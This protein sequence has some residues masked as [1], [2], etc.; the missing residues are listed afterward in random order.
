MNNNPPYSPKPQKAMR[1]KKTIF[2]L[3]SALFVGATLGLP[4]ALQAQAPGSMP[5]LP[6]DTAVRIGKLPNGLTYFI[7]HNEEPKGRAEFYIA[8]KVGS[9]QEE[10]SQQGLAHFLEHIAFNGTK[11]FPGKGI[12][13]FLESI[14]ASF[15]GNINAYTSFDRTVYTLMKIPVPRRSIV[16]SCIL[17][18]HDWSSFISLEDKEIDAERGVIEEEWRRSNN[19]DMRNSEKLLGVA[20]PGNKYGKRLPIGKMDIV[21]NFP[22]QV[23]RDYYKKWYRPDL[24]SVIIV[25]D[26]DVN[27]V[28]A[29]LKK[30]FADIPAPVNAAERVYV[31]VEDNDKPIVGI[32]SDKEATQNSLVIAYKSDVTPRDVRASIMGPL[33][34]YINT[35]VTTMV[36]QRFSD[37][38]KKPNAPFTGASLEVGNYIVAKTKDASTFGATFKEGQWEPALKALVAEIARIK[39]YG[40]TPAEFDRAKKDFLVNEKNTYNERDKRTSETWAEIYVDYFDDGGY[41]LDIPTY[42]QLIQG[43][44]AQ[45]PLDQINAMMQEMDLE[46]NVLVALTSV[47]KPGVKLPSVAELTE[48]YLAYTKQQVEAPKNEVSNEKLIDKLPTKG[49]IVKEEKN[50]QYGSTVWTLSNGTKVYFKKTD[51]KEDEILFKGQ[52]KGGYYNFTKPTA[53]D[54]KVLNAVSALGGLGKFDASALEKALTGRLAAITSSVSGIS[55]DVAGS[56]TKEDLETLLQLLYLKFTAVRSDKEAFQAWQERTISE[57][58]ASKANPLSFLGDS[59]TRYLFP[60]NPERYP[61]S[62]QE[63]KG[64]NY[65]KALQLF[66]SRFANARGFDFYFVGNI[67][68]AVLRPLVEQ[69]IAALPAQKV[70]TDKAYT[71]RVPVERLGTNKK[72]YSAPM[73]TPMGIVIDGLSLPSTYSQQEV[74][75]AAVLESILDQLYTK[76]IREDAGGAYSVGVTSEVGRFP[77]PRTSVTVQFQT[78]PAKAVA[79]NEL[80]FKGLEG[81]AKEGPSAEYFDKAVKNMKKAHGENLRK[82]SYWLAQLS[83]F[84]SQGF[85]FV[86]DYDKVLDAVTPQAVQALTKKLYDSKDRTSILFR[87][88]EV[89]EKK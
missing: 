70:Y 77:S 4:S 13:N 49:K 87:S 67:D 53:T 20:F 50:A 39:K 79:M 82:N 24:Q 54:L 85:D 12:I 45:L 25:G 58:E 36:N 71:N 46:K 22:Y 47:E 75:T 88:T 2:S 60:N 14:G 44:V 68:E 69:Y 29:Q 57:L 64:A 73:A 5:P 28:E 48:K 42:Y 89:K 26:V 61:L 55:D 15:G 40:F 31:P 9:M 59:I 16:D 10:D 83:R 74:L 41:L 38:T 65:E 37:I 17:V 19:G 27:Y 30:I 43:L 35:I 6:I 86:T 62:V 80:V 81:I 63:V 52:R 7:R 84:Y 18:L 56:T 3:L 32:V 51:Y 76:T 11:H 33:E 78:D 21:R 72:E 23:L 1:L 8:Q 66:R 34:D